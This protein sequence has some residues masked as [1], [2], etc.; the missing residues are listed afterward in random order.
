MAR[1]NR[2][3][4]LLVLALAFSGCATTGALRE[5][6]NAEFLQEYDRAILE[7]TKALR[8]NPDNR[9]ARFHYWLRSTVCSR[10]AHG[11]RFAS[12]GRD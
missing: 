2:L 12:P 5:G 8:E 7:Y 11:R 10:A 6:Q 4:A 1:G 9:D 3:A